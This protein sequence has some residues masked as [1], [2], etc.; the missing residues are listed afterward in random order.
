MSGNKFFDILLVDDDEDLTNLL[1]KQIKGSGYRCHTCKSIEEATQ[2]LTTHVPHVIV[3]DINLGEEK[4]WP[5][6]PWIKQRPQFQTTK[7]FMSSREIS[8]TTILKAKSHGVDEILAKPLNAVALV[9]KLR[10]TLFNNEVLKHAFTKRPSL[11]CQMV[12]TH[13]KINEVSFVIVSPVKFSQK[14]DI[15][16]DSNFFRELNLTG[17]KFR[18]V[19][20]SRPAA[21]GNYGTEVTFRGM[22]EELAQK[23]RK[24]KLK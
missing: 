21:D 20:N 3:L 10:K 22:N 4:S 23:I 8:R 13:N 7:I 9:Q 19:D 2:Y 15:H 17:L 1:S 12:A 16:V 24:I 18:T 6:L 5:L 11:Q 14:T